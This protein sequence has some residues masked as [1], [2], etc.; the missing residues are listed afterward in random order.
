MFA[1]PYSVATT[2]QPSAFVGDATTNVVGGY[3]NNDTTQPS[4]LVY[5]RGTC[6]N[7]GTLYT[8]TQFYW[9]YG[10][11]VFAS[12]PVDITQTGVFRMDALM[13]LDVAHISAQEA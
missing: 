12:T 10:N 7:M 2:L 6:G 4:C 13:C 9:S 3:A 11:G 5:V 1:L 8:I